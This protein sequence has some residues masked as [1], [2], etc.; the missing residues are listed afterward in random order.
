MKG[1]MQLLDFED[2]SSE[3]LKAILLQCFVTPI[4]LKA[5]QVIIIYCIHSNNYS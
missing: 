1:A 5:D 3:P 2:P 4:F